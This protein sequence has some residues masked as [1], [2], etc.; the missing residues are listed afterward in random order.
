MNKRVFYRLLSMGWLV[1]Y[2]A[3]AGVAAHERPLDLAM[4]TLLPL[5]LLV[6]GAMIDVKSTR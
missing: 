2:A 1:A 3:T 6:I 4:L 5:T